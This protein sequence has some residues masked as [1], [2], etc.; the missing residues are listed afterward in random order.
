VRRRKL[1][2]DK[3]DPFSKVFIQNSPY[4]KAPRSPLD[5]PKKRALKKKVE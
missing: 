3:E 5:S 1:K 2:I 4:R